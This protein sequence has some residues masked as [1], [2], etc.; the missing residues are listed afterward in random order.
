[1]IRLDPGSPAA[2]APEGHNSAA[3]NGGEDWMRAL[4]ETGP[5]PRTDPLAPPA[6]ARQADAALAGVQPPRTR[7]TPAADKPKGQD[8]LGA[9]AALRA[10]AGALAQADTAGSAWGCRVLEAAP[11][12]QGH[13]HPVPD[14]DEGRLPGPASPST[15]ASRPLRMLQTAQATPTASQTQA[16]A[17]ATLAHPAGQAPASASAPGPLGGDRAMPT[18]AG[19]ASPG[20]SAGAETAL[21]PGPTRQS[22]TAVAGSPASPEAAATRAQ[23]SAAPGMPAG[24]NAKPGAAPAGLPQAK[25]PDAGQGVRAA[26]PTAADGASGRGDQAESRD[27]DKGSPDATDAFAA[28]LKVLAAG[29]APATSSYA[30]GSAVPG[31][32]AVLG[33]PPAAAA[34]SPSSALGAAPMAPAALAAALQTALKPLLPV[35]P[36]ESVQFRVQAGKLGEVTVSLREEAGSLVAKVEASGALAQQALRDAAP[37]LTAAFRDGGQPLAR[38]ELQRQETTSGRAAQGR[39]GKDSGQDNGQDNGQDGAQARQD[40]HQDRP[41]AGALEAAEGR[42]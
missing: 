36:G 12:G 24:S 41:Q 19:S 29:T 23:G 20:Y 17:P 15:P 34:G 32:N 4:V 27:G 38:L 18:A 22:G 7:P 31:A 6:A 33:T 11:K 2:P 8:P 10:A 16:P 30:P 35:Q 40:R 39:Q 9:L 26:A 3:G 37:L 42:S 21:I 5:Q 14:A 1:M 13:G 28:R 25:G